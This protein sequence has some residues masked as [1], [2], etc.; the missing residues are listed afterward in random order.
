MLKKVLS[1]I[2]FSLCVLLGILCGI[3]F[4]MHNNKTI[5][6]KT[7]LSSQAY[8]YLPVEAKEFIEQHYNETGEVLLTEK[9][10]QENEYYLNPLYVDY[11]ASSSAEEYEVIPTVLVTDYIYSD[12][13]TATSLP[14]KFD[15]RN[16]NN[17]NYITPLK[18]QGNKGICWSFATMEQAESYLLVKNNQTYDST[19]KNVFSA[20]H[21]DYVTA[22]NTIVDMTSSIYSVGRELGS[23]GSFDLIVPYAMD[24]LSYVRENWISYYDTRT[25]LEYSY[26]FNYTNSPLSGGASLELNSTIDMPNI[27][28]AHTDPSLRTEYLNRVKEAIMLYGGAYVATYSPTEKC[29]TSINGNRFIYGDGMCRSTLHAMQIIGWDDNYSYNICSGVIKDDQYYISNDVSNCS[30]TV[31]SKKGAWLLRNSWGTSS[32]Y[33]YLAYDSKGSDI[34]I[35]TDISSKTWANNYRDASFIRLKNTFNELKVKYTRKFNQEEILNKIK[36]ELSSQN[37]KYDFYVSPDG[38][39]NNLTLLGSITSDLPGIYTFKPRSEVS[40]N[41]EYFTVYIKSENGLLSDSSLNVYTTDD[42]GMPEIKTQNKTHEPKDGDTE[43]VFR[44]V[45]QTTGI[46]DNKNIEYRIGIKNDNNE[47]VDLEEIAGIDYQYNN[48][49]GGLVY[50]KIYLFGDLKRGKYTLQTLYNGNV[51]SE[52]DITLKR[53]V[54]K[55]SQAGTKNDPYLVTDAEELDYIRRHGNKYYKLKNDIDLTFETSDPEGL[56][57]NDGKGWEPLFNGTITLN[58]GNVNYSETNPP[59]TGGFD[60]NNKKIIGLNINREDEDFVGLFSSIYN[61]DDDNVYVKNVILENANIKGRNYVGALAGFIGSKYYSNCT[62]IQNI[63]NHNGYVFGQN[64]AAGII[65]YYQGGGIGTSSCT[66]DLGGLYNDSKIEGY[67]R[68]AGIIGYMK[69]IDNVNSSLRAHDLQSIGELSAVKVN[70]SSPNT[71]GLISNI[72]SYKRRYR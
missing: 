43:Y 34:N 15:L 61:Y 24:G 39:D 58:N 44:V 52:S 25:Q 2:T 47:F 63:A 54:V 17:M 53:S 45:S 62:I 55:F 10:K 40:L 33:L 12:Y 68:V 28:L 48:I 65:G 7:V 72:K 16:Y 37:E 36:I 31:I 35:A 5:D 30:G 20:R 57:Y 4:R 6:I 50:S 11:L 46:S 41:S 66:Y 3:L 32:P 69:T 27:W 8:S 56:F 70:N 1:C 60:G 64:Y 21:A 29:S 13:A 59:F 14:S 9:N 26:V 67:N 23:G 51:L 49:G 71:S 22:F 19:Q 42:L 38:T 18:N